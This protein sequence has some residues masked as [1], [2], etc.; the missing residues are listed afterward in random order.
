MNPSRRS[1]QAS[2]LQSSSVATSHDH[3]LY[4]QTYR[5][6]CHAIKLDRLG[7]YV[8]ASQQYKKVIE[9]FKDLMQ[10]CDQDIRI[11]RQQLEQKMNEYVHRSEQLDRYNTGLANGVPA[12]AH[13]DA[14]MHRLYNVP[15]DIHDQVEGDEDDEDDDEARLIRWHLQ[16]GKFSMIQGQVNEKKGH[17][18]EALEYFM[19]SAD[20]YKKAYED[21]AHDPQRRAFAK[22]MCLNAV[23]KA[24]ELKA[25]TM[26]QKTQLL[27]VRNEK[28]RPALGR[29]RAS[30]TSS[31]RSAVSV[32]SS[33]CVNGKTA[34]CD[35]PQSSSSTGDLLAQRL[36]SAELQVLKYSSNVNNNIFL[37]WIDDTG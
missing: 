35:S 37:P 22:N 27:S 12:A 2:R 32:E 5:A 25:M 21:L 19:D 30:S 16:K 9:M 18:E 34:T 4:T 7:Q 24:E 28:T 20:W 1:V 36:S 31:T 17:V 6:A 8:Q 33:S 29:H 15:D 26:H 14:E 11:E 3:D 13:P 10:L 23:D